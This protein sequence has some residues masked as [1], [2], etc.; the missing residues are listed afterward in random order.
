MF[1]LDYT[2][3]A[4]CLYFLKM[5]GVTPFIIILTIFYSKMANLHRDTR[6]FVMM[7]YFLITIGLCY[8]IFLPN[9]ESVR[10]DS[11]ADKLNNSLPKTRRIYLGIYF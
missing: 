8:F 9:L 3:E 10:L 5:Y 1:I 4:A 7:G 6:F 2:G 11:V